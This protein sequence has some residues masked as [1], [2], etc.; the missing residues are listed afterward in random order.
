M[1]KKSLSDKLNR[2]HTDQILPKETGRQ[3]KIEKQKPEKKAEKRSLKRAA[4][5]N[6]SKENIEQEEF[7][8]EE[9]DEFLIQKSLE[10]AKRNARWDK[11]MNIVHVILILACIYTGVLIYGAAVTTYVYDDSGEVT[12]QRMNISDISAR[13]EY[14][15]IY[16]YYEACRG[17]YECT[18]LLDYRLGAGV[19]DPLMIA[20]EYEALLDTVENLSIKTDALSVDTGYSRI[21]SML[22]SWIQSDIAVYLQNMSSAI[23]Q[24]DSTAAN[25]ALQDKDRVYN[26]FMLITQNM[27]VVGENIKGVDLASIRHWTPE[28]YI[29]EEINGETS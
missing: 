25:N 19:E 26:D 18:L 22:L 29:D 1:K 16:Y 12:A 4:K 15:K 21:K 2:L 17:L 6:G 27:A 9:H 11:T 24:N 20:P 3:V 13:K 28:N 14:E 23:S 7:L 5:E 10:E 8:L